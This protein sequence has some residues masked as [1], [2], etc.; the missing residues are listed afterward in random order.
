MEKEQQAR[1]SIREV[2]ATAMW[3]IVI[4]RSSCIK[5]LDVMPSST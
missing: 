4:V 2:Q 5:E 1:L 3:L